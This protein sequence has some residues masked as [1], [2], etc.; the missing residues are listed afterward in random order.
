MAMKSLL[1]T[2]GVLA[3][4]SACQSAPGEA[5]DYSGLFER[6]DEEFGWSGGDGAYSIALPKDR[7][8]WLFGDSY[9]S[10]VDRGVRLNIEPRFGNTVAIQ[11]NPEPG[12]EASPMKHAPVFDWGP[13]AS[14]GWLPLHD[15]T[16]QD[17]A[18][19]ASLKRALALELPVIA[20][21]MHGI[22]VGEDLVVFSTP[23]TRSDC[24]DCGIFAFKVHGS[25]ANIIQGVARPYEEWGYERG[26]GWAVDRRPAQRFVS[27]SSAAESLDDPG[28]VAWGTFVMQDPDNTETLYIYGHR[29]TASTDDLLLARVQN[30]K[31]AK[32]VLAF[33]RWEFWSEG[34]WVTEAARASSVLTDTAVEVSVI[35][36]PAI[37]GRGFALVQ[38]GDVL[39]GEVEVAVAAQPWGPFT[40]EYTLSL[41]DCPVAGFDPG[42]QYLTY[43]AKAHPH[44]SAGDDVLV[45]LINIPIAAAKG[46]AITSTRHYVPRFVRIPWGEILTHDRSSP[47][48]CER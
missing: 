18:V 16:L 10:E 14:S 32:D 34:A 30:V 15:A 7:T 8:L 47:E 21:P 5:R 28:L 31:D 26:Q 17:V 6:R 22:V 44:L 12:E 27:H 38:S 41:A 3:L 1:Q 29:E 23:V 33:E 11:G 4:L 39:K 43:A 19:P 42:E 35:P 13:P 20:W 37:Y 24:T 2:F 48:R 36:L 45:S 46:S 40:Q 25:V 9:L